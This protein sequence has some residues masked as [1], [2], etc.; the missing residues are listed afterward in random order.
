MI[1]KNIHVSCLKSTFIEYLDGIQLRYYVP[2]IKL[3]GRTAKSIPDGLVMMPTCIP[4][5]DAC[6]HSGIRN[7]HLHTLY[8]G[9]VTR[10]VVISY[11]WWT[12]LQATNTL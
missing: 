10:W 1:N 4:C 5:N 3:Y 8:K 12:C 11:K 2:C 9:W 7:V 6:F